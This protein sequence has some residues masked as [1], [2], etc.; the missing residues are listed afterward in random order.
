MTTQEADIIVVA[1]PA[2]NKD[3]AALRHLFFDTA[4]NCARLTMR[5]V[6]PTR[7]SLLLTSRF[8]SAAA[9]L[10]LTLCMR[11]KVFHKHLCWG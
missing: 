3:T 6:V 11:V 1:E 5:C 7:M 10:D 4:Q 2:V 9:V 8:N